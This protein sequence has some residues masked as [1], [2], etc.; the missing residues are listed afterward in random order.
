VPAIPAFR[1]PK[2]EDLKVQA[3]LGYIVRPFQKKKGGE[4]ED[5]RKE[6][7]REG[8]ERGERRRA[9]KGREWEKKKSMH[10]K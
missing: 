6:K 2:E 7:E 3:S 4:R 9:E 10:C 8:E 1:M 5:E